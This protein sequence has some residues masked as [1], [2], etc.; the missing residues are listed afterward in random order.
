[1][2]PDDKPTTDTGVNEELVVPSPNSPCEL[3]PQHF[4]APSATAHVEFSP[5]VI[6]V[7]PLVSPVTC[8]GELESV[9]VPSPN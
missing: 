7:T 2:T 5:A 6:A 8:T 9:L 4:S 1:V 3:L